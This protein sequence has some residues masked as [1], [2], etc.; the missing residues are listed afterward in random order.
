VSHASCFHM[1]VRELATELGV[2]VEPA[3]TSVIDHF[4]YAAADATH[5]SI[6]ASG[7]ADS[8]AVFGGRQPVGRAAERAPCLP[9]C[10]VSGSCDNAGVCA[11]RRTLFVSKQHNHAEPSCKTP[12]ERRTCAALTLPRML[13][14]ASGVQGHR[15]VRASGQHPGGLLHFFVHVSALPIRSAGLQPGTAAHLTSST[16]ASSAPNF[17]GE[18]INHGANLHL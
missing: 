17:K 4:N 12:Y 11:R 6:L 14:G 10:L 13:A 9:A 1:Q 3:G 8:K 7:F 16:A 2:D 5:T 15:P 18:R